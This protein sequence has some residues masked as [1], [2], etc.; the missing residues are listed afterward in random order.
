MPESVNLMS[1]CSVP[2]LVK[3]EISPNK[4]SSLA[5]LLN[6]TFRLTSAN[7]SIGSHSGLLVLPPCTCTDHLSFV[8]VQTKIQKPKKNPCLP[9]PV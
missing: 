7:V 5:N 3:Q 1:P 4:L 9:L 2:Y 6:E 8:T